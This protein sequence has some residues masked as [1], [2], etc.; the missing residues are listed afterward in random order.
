[1][2]TTTLEDRAQPVTHA[3]RA[4]LR[5]IGRGLNDTEIAA[6]LATSDTA[7]AHSIGR[8]IAKL[9]LR[10]RAAAIVYAFDH[11]IVTPGPE[12]VPSGRFRISALGPLRAWNDAKPLDL[13]PV[14]QQALLAALVLRPDRTVSQRELL[15]SVWGLDAPVGNVVPVYIYRLRQSLRSGDD[16]SDSMIVRDRSGYRFRGEGVRVDTAQ[17]DALAAEAETAQRAGDLA[18]AVGTLSRAIGLFHGE[19][20]A[21]LPGPFAEL[22]RLRLTDRRLSLSLRKAEWQL[23]LGKHAE[24]IE[25]ISESATAHPHSEPVAA[26]LMHALATSGRRAEALAVYTRL[27]TR[28]AEDLGVEPG[29]RLRHLHGAVLRGEDRS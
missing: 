7:V 16:R 2:P 29:A 12:P 26:L 17:L 19:P 10:D 20:L 22:E 9:G 18:A 13:G 1:M 14:R 4:V 11:G 8:L 21:G 5:G 3:E 27:R 6:A 15:E 28:L 25:E 23:R 24:A